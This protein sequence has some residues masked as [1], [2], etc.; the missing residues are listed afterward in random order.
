[1]VLPHRT[2]ALPVVQA[3]PFQRSS[4]PQSTAAHGGQQGQFDVV[5][6]R[7]VK[8]ASSAVHGD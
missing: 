8:V 1:M 2:V 6:E 7:R 3:F 4:T 5:A